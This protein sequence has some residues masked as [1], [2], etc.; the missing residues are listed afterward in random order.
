[1][2]IYT[3]NG[4]ESRRD[5][6]ESLAD[7]FGLKLDVVLTLACFLGASEDFDGLVTELDNISM[8]EEY[9]RD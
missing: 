1:M 5:Y 6:L 4:Y 2:S 7:D 3:D 8:L 9:Q